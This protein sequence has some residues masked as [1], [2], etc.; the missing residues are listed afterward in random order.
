[1]SEQDRFEDDVVYA[2]TRTGE[3]FRTEQ[4][5][6]VSGGLD[7]GR[8]RWRRRSAAAVVSGT[9]ALAVVATGA[10]YLSGSAG[11]SPAGTVLTAAAEPAAGSGTGTG[12]GT[13]SASPTPSGSATAEPPVITGDE[14]LAT[15]KALLPKG[16]V[17]NGSGR[18]TDDSSGPGNGTFAAA[19]LVF[20][21]GQGKSLISVAIQ[22]HRKGQSQPRTCP[23]DLKTAR[24]DS[25]A[26]TVLPDGSRLL[27]SQ[28]YEYPDHRADTKQWLAQLAGPDGREILVSEWNSPQEKG[29]PDS[30]RNPPLG[31]DQ[32]KSVATDKS[33]DRIVAA[34]QYDGVDTEPL[35]T[36][37]SLEDREA[38]FAG[39]LPAGAR[40]TARDGS[41]IYATFQVSSGTTTG[42]VI[43]KVENWSKQAG[44]TQLGELFK[45]A[46][47][48]PDGTKVVEY[49]PGSA[50]AGSAQPMVDT[51]HPGGLR[52]MVTLGSGP[53][54]GGRTAGVLTLDQ[55]RAIAT[56]AQWKLRK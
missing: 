53:A 19:D 20:D 45:D 41:Q 28:G 34:V 15:F 23:A 46:T 39:L 38:V 32:L 30:R 49:G 18:G 48:L 52:V 29:A 51:L 21:D 56:S 4:A 27:L 14:V 22:K 43:L 2:L 1:M 7:R 35:D 50:K 5:P 12:G 55:L 11:N 26:V 37:L 8:R 10:V 13:G 42:P 54:K 25:C 31:L 24:L 16:T 40:V 36:G 33:W 9:A 44:D 17:S 6:L 3:G 47:T